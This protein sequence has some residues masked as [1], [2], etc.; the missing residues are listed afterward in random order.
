MTENKEGKNTKKAQAIEPK[1][2]PREMSGFKWVNG[3]ILEK[4]AF[5]GSVVF[6]LTAIVFLVFE[7]VFPAENWPYIFFDLAISFAFAGET[8]THWRFNRKF[9]FITAACSALFVI[10]CLLRVFGVISA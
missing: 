8:L 1:D 6:L 5:V 10:L 9:A 2:S 3:S 4:S 7:F